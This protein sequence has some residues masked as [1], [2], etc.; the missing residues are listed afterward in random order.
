MNLVVLLARLFLSK[1]L[2]PVRRCMCLYP[3]KKYWFI[4]SGVCLEND[5]ARL[6][7]SI[8]F[9]KSSCLSVPLMYIFKAGG[10]VLFLLSTEG[11]LQV[12]QL[13]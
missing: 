6:S 13:L 3:C 5:V 2:L 7:E 10:A 8:A 9:C 4:F 11:I 1:S 12:R